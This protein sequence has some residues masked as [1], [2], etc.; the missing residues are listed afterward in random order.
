MAVRNFRVSGL[1]THQNT[2]YILDLGRLRERRDP[3]KPKSKRP[4]PSNSLRRIASPPADSI[5]S[6]GRRLQL[7]KSLK[8]PAGP[9]MFRMRGEN[10]RLDKIM[11]MVERKPDGNLERDSQRR[12]HMRKRCCFTQLHSG[13]GQTAYVGFSFR[14]AFALPL[15]SSTRALECIAAFVFKSLR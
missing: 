11:F 6:L 3:S 12:Q 15:V 1:G 4:R 5:A 13:A 2:V 9:D 14:L 7:T 8:Q 10:G